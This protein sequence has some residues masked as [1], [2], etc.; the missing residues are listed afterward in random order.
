MVVGLSS[1]EFSFQV[2]YSKCQCSFDF[3]LFAILESNRYF[4]FT[5]G[6]YDF[7]MMNSGAKRYIPGLEIG[8]S[9]FLNT[10]M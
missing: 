5:N 3:E 10:V 4:C 6:E 7:L 8:R 1:D 9:I 2:S